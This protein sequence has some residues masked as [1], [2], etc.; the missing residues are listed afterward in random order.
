MKL[1][2][3]TNEK[4][5]KGGKRNKIII[6]A[7]LISL[8]IIAAAVVFI[9]YTYSGMAM[10]VSAPV[11]ICGM[12]EHTH[13]P[14]CY[15]KVLA[16]GYDEEGNPV[17]TEASTESDSD[18]IYTTPADE[19]VS[20]TSVTTD[21]ATTAPETTIGTA[22]ET[23]ASTEPE[24]TAEATTIEE[25]EAET[26]AVTDAA[27]TAPET[28]PET[29]PE[30]TTEAPTTTEAAPST[31]ATTEAPTTEAPTVPSTEAAVTEAP[32]S[33]DETAAESE[34]TIAPETSNDLKASMFNRNVL[35]IGID[36]PL[37]TVTFSTTEAAS[38]PE[39]TTSDPETVTDETVVE[40]VTEP[41]TKHVHTDACYKYILIC[42]KPEHVHTAACYPTTEEKTTVDEAT[43]NE[44]TINETTIDETTANE[45]TVDETASEFAAAEETTEDILT[46]ENCVLCQQGVIHGHATG[47]TLASSI[48]APKAQQKSGL[49]GITGAAGGIGITATA[50]PLGFS[51][52]LNDFVSAVTL[53]DSSNNILNPSTYTF[54]KGNSYVFDIQFVESA[55]LQ[56]YNETSGGVRYMTYQ[57]PSTIKVIQAE[58][59]KPIYSMNPTV[60]VGE[61]D[62]S[63]SGLVTVRFYDLNRDGVPEDVNNDRI[64]DNFIDIY[65]D[66]QFNLKLTAKFDGSGSQSINFGNAEADK[67]IIFQVTEPAGPSLSVW[68]YNVDTPV[69]S[70]VDKKLY[71]RIY[72][73]PNNGNVYDVHVRDYITLTAN[74]VA[75]NYNQ[76]G[77]ITI[78]AVNGKTYNIATLNS[79]ITYDGPDGSGKYYFDIPLGDLSATDYVDI[80]YTVDIADYINSLS[81][82]N[83]Y[84]VSARNDVETAGKVAPGGAATNTAKSNVTKTISA[85]NQAKIYL[86]KDNQNYDAASKSWAFRVYV[87]AQDADLTNVV[88]SDYMTLKADNGNL[89]NFDM[90]GKITVTQV[91]SNMPSFTIQSITDLITYTGPDGNGRYYFNIPIGNLPKDKYVDIY[92]KVDI[93]SFISQIG[94]DTANFSIANYAAATADNATSVSK[95]VTPGAVSTAFIGKY[96]WANS[97][98]GYSKDGYGQWGSWY[99]G[100]GTTA[101]NGCEITDTLIG[102]MGF[103]PGQ[104]ATITFTT[105]PATT[106]PPTI[107]KALPDN[108]T[109][110]TF[111]VPAATATNP[112]TGLPYGKIV[113]AEI[114]S[115]TN[116]DPSITYSYPGGYYYTKILNIS[117]YTTGK[118]TNN[119]KVVFPDS[120]IPVE[121]NRDITVK[122]PTV[123]NIKM[124]KKGAIVHSGTKEYAEWTIDYT[125]PGILET[126]PVWLS[127]YTRI[128]S[129]LNGQLTTWSHRYIE[130]NPDDIIS[131]KAITIDGSLQ[132]KTLLKG[133]DYTIIVSGNSWYLSFNPNATSVTDAYMKDPTTGSF[134]PFSKTTVL[135]ITV[136]TPFERKIYN[137]NTLSDVTVKDEIDI[138]EAAYMNWIYNY[139]TGY[140][141]QTGSS[142]LSV[143]AN[144]YVYAPIYKQV[145]ANG[146]VLTYTTSIDFTMADPVNVAEMI[147]AGIED[148][149][150]SNLEYVQNS[151]IIYDETNQK[152]YGLYDTSSRADLLYQDQTQFTTTGT[153]TYFSA[154]DATH[155][156]FKFNLTDLK[157]ITGKTENSTTIPSTASEPTAG[158]YNTSQKITVYYKMQPKSDVYGMHPY[159]NKIS[160]GSF[161]STVTSAEAGTKIVSKTLE[162][163]NIGSVALTTININTTGV[164][165]LKN[166]DRITVTD[167]MN[168]NLLLAPNTIK[169]WT[170]DTSGNKIGSPHPLTVDTGELWSYSL[171]SER[172]VKFIL[173]D[174]VPL[175]LE[176]GSLVIGTINKYVSISNAVKVE[177]L[178]STGD[179]NYFHI[180]DTSAW[181]LGGSDGLTVFKRDSADPTKR[182]AGAL[183]ALYM[184]IPAGTEYSGFDVESLKAA[185]AGIPSVKQF[186]TPPMDFY[187]IGYGTT[188]NDGNA[189]IK[190]PWMTPTHNAIYALVEITAPGGY[191]LPSDPV[192]FFSYST[193]DSAQIT[194]LAPKIVSQKAG[195][196]TITN[197]AAQNSAVIKGK[198]AVTGTIEDG[199]VEEATPFTFD[200]AQVDAT[201]KQPLASSVYNTSTYTVGAAPF[202]FTLLNLPDGDSWF[203]VTERQNS[204]SSSWQYDTSEYLVKVNINGTATP[205]VTYYKQ[206]NTTTAVSEMV[207]TNNYGAA[208]SGDIII[209]GKKV[210]T[211]NAPTANKDFVFALSECNAVGE[212]I[213]PSTVVPTP[214]T[215]TAHTNGAGEYAFEFPKITG[216]AP[217]TYYFKIEEANDGSANW[218]YDG[219]KIVKVTVEPNGDVIIEYPESEILGGITTGDSQKITINPVVINDA[220]TT[221][222]GLFTASGETD[223]PN[224]WQNFNGSSSN[225]YGYTVLGVR[226]SAAFEMLWANDGGSLRLIT[227]AAYC[228]NLDIST[229]QDGGQYFPDFNYQGNEEALW[230]TRNGFMSS[231]YRYSTTW[232]G[233]QNLASV[234]T[235]T[236]E[237]NL[238]NDEAYIAT[239]L[240]IWHF[241]DG[242]N[243]QY[244][245]GSY[246]VY[247]PRVPTESLRIWNAYKA[248]VAAASAAK[249]SGEVITELQMDVSLDLSDA[250]LTNSIYGPVKIKVDVLP[251]GFV[252]LSNVAVTLTPANGATV[253][254]DSAGTVPVTGTLHDG[255]QFYVR[256]A[257]GTAAGEELVT[258]TATLNDSIEVTDVYIFDKPYDGPGWYAIQ[259]ITGVAKVIRP[260]SLTANAKLYNNATGELKFINTYKEPYSLTLTKKTDPANAW[261][262][263]EEFDFT[264]TFA[265]PVVCGDTSTGADKFTSADGGKTW[266]GKLT[267]TKQSITFTDIPAGTYYLIVENT[268]NGNYVVDHIETTA[269]SS[270]SID[271]ETKAISGYMNKAYIEVTYVN[272]YN[273]PTTEV[274]LPIYKTV[275]GTGAPSATFNFRLTRLTADPYDSVSGTISVN[276]KLTADTQTISITN[277]GTNNFVIPGLEKGKTY[278]YFVEELPNDSGGFNWSYSKEGYAVYITVNDDLTT[279]ITYKYRDVSR[280][281]DAVTIRPYDA[282]SRINFTNTYVPPSSEFD[283][284]VEKKIIGTTTTNKTFTFKI[285]RV[286]DDTGNT[287]WTGPT[288]EGYSTTIT[289]NGAGTNVFTIKNLADGTYYYKVTELP[290]AGDTN[291]IYDDIVYI[292]KV[293]VLNNH[294]VVYYPDGTIKGIVTDVVAEDQTININPPGSIDFAAPGTAFE[295]NGYYDST[296]SFNGSG[297]YEYK[298][299]YGYGYDYIYFMNAV[300][301]SNTIVGAAYCIDEF[302]YGTN[303]ASTPY[304][305]LAG[306]MARYDATYEQILWL[307]R[308]G[309]MS[310]GS[311]GSASWSGNNNLTELRTLTNVP[312]LTAD[313]AYCA[314]QFAIWHFTNGTNFTWDTGSYQIKDYN[315]T[316]DASNIYAAYTALVNAANAAKNAG[317]V[318]KDLTLGVNFDTSGATLS[319]GWYGPVKLH[320]NI[321]PADF[322]DKSIIPIYLTLLNGTAISRTSGG[323][324]YTGPYYDSGTNN[325]FYVNVGSAST[326]N[327][328]ELVKAEAMLSGAID[329]KDVHIFNSKTVNGD[330]D[331]AGYQAIAGVAV[332]KRDVE[333]KAAATLYYG[334]TEGRLTFQNK[335][336][337]I[338]VSFF[339]G[340]EDKPLDYSAD[341]ALP[342]AVFELYTSADGGAHLTPFIP[343]KTATSG[344][345]GYV[346]FTQL[347]V[348]STYYMK[349]ITSPSGYEENKKLYKIDVLSTAGI[350]QAHYNIYYLASDSTWKAVAQSGD[351]PFIIYN[352]KIGPRM[353]ETGG[354]GLL[355]FSIIGGSLLT[356]TAGGFV[357]NRKLQYARSQRL[358]NT[359]F[360][361]Y[362]K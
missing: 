42:T 96:G 6:R 318:I 152:Y 106:P 126:Y 50:A 11:P 115:V 234:Q 274:T 248:L 117:A 99:V 101:I 316:V 187:Y 277:S 64:N 122:V 228:I 113:K 37:A 229:A 70:P 254:S 243:W 79:Q 98:W 344:S 288:G 314:T 235:L 53:R 33:A 215:V 89:V 4:T 80:Y 114:T 322:T 49:R 241:T 354:S 312:G 132:D 67:T 275:Q 121:Y 47:S 338:D 108:G 291:W 69:Y 301:G 156:K 209:K 92:Y 63:L 159:T 249:G 136:R 5:L 90:R 266:T 184:W 259:A 262:A 165:L 182:P 58:T 163:A 45:T 112:A 252:N 137:G 211:G 173:P 308:N 296:D 7:A 78:T 55:T 295:I 142:P 267:Y 3:S 166:S 223:L 351:S 32:T 217:G 177:G 66:A 335:L 219:A 183:F 240:A 148:I 311:R 12:E 141:W 171:V 271:G 21:A 110:F 293:V 294:A 287:V 238:T 360:D 362:K 324:S 30:P 179:S 250:A 124:E 233:T 104:I 349:E 198:K 127:D 340:D 150:D 129:N 201:T 8:G 27:T 317:E 244:D 186:G 245:T 242:I 31:E 65:T 265:N 273:I 205:V 14:E 200:L 355:W 149:F 15:E 103:M 168:V 169:V 151:L 72:V 348:G 175:R 147:A 282:S 263:G 326:D 303:D 24:T 57:L 162:P 172:E 43:A 193:P 251:A 68:K 119:V 158:W 220:L 280:A 164:N 286:T 350:S 109:S 17:T 279:T 224:V 189:F 91:N 307:I 199:S 93:S 332:V 176:Y 86:Y 358:N 48:T 52:S 73:Y 304:Y 59:Q 135:E 195:V 212:I 74:S 71:F 226:K 188:G 107:T 2:N 299:P 196:I 105:D 185:R 272:K 356:L 84:T 284:P 85:T 306:L 46:E 87:S 25:T 102:G 144:A 361:S 210:V 123:D 120:Q 330:P 289:I 281:W 62:I 260:V 140:Y 97:L 214:L 100:N 138:A 174:D 359:S 315:N 319:G 116:T 167:V 181:A 82:P 213:S 290:D 320:V 283:I 131:V 337:T 268:L 29:T 246:Q 305:D 331:W 154:V 118:Y 309:F 323:A 253:Y 202:S 206:P 258:A 227:G 197:D 334:A 77:K 160:M 75:T 44:T 111:T 357:F 143:P 35:S 178:D 194:A 352:I 26:A 38:A 298:V 342:G 333:L 257:A 207:F 19:T 347:T 221:K 134:S 321:V 23:E 133:T 231:G 28:T 83:N 191:S 345:N 313:E 302:V 208:Q 22:A 54:I 145:S 343:A 255:D 327:I 1:T 51:S 297:A 336:K 346:L 61:Y 125:I 218:T 329:V 170:M 16:C 325:V 180:T 232:Y 285:E 20:E 192:N 264:V 10:E 216:I 60:P 222:E 203:K 39:I 225:L 41:T 204:T 300:D 270:Y 190:S 276:D 36:M 94:A 157:L 236:G 339:K 155:T 239:Q 95:S 153:G 13:G 237:M 230:L 88:L 269:D 341:A 40:P 34:A 353:P 261:T 130:I 256:V 9:L 247:D 128:Y 146:N 18:S 310:E 81:D 76:Q 161:S 292:I 56:F 139:V 278:W 328:L